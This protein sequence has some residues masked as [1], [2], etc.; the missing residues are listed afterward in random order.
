MSDEIEQLQM[1][2]STA[3]WT[4]AVRA[5]E[6]ARPDHLFNDPWASALA[7]AEGMGWIS[8]RSPENVVSMVLRTR[9]FDDFL[10][11][12]VNN[13]NVRQIILMAAGLDTRAFR[14]SWPQNTRIFELDQTA[15]LEYKEQ[16]L[17]LALAEPT[18]DRSVVS[19]DITST[20][21]RTLRDAGFDANKPSVWLLEGFLFYLRFEH[22]TDTL[23]RVLNLAAPGSHIGF[24]IIDNVTLTSELMRDWI[25]MQAKEGAPWIG[26]LDDPD[27]FLA[28]RN[29]KAR[30]IPIGAPEANYDRWNYPVIPV[31][32]PGMPHYWFVVGKKE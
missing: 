1:L 5:Q 7:G 11:D 15:V 26:S 12:V 17:R 30:V 16:I 8:Q 10:Q 19:V 25:E 32:M 6:S 18:C 28:E 21:E 31:T 9:F 4:A 3:R 14:L 13:N 27:G 22:L 23:D 24:D 2:G 29:W 20:W